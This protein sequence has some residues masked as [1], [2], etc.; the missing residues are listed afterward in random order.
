MAKTKT[1]PADLVDPMATVKNG[2]PRPDAG[3][4]ALRLAES[5]RDVPT[6]QELAKMAPLQR[7]QACLQGPSLILPGDLSFGQWA[8][9]GPVL[10]QL[11]T[12]LQFAIGDWLNYGENRYGEKYAQVADTLAYDRA[13]LMNVAWVSR[14]IE[15]SR[16]REIVPFAYHQEVAAAGLSV[17]DREELLDRAVQGTDGQGRPILVGRAAFRAFVRDYR[18]LRALPDPVKPGKV[19]ALGDKVAKD[20]AAA[21]EEVAEANAVAAESDAIF[22]DESPSLVTVRQSMVDPVFGG[23]RPPDDMRDA[24]TP[25]FFV[26]PSLAPSQW[27]VPEDTDLSDE[28]VAA[29]LEPDASRLNEEAFA[30]SLQDKLFDMEGQVASLTAQM[31][32]LSEIPYQEQPWGTWLRISEGHTKR[33]KALQGRLEERGQSYTLA[34]VLEISIDKACEALKVKVAE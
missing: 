13:Y 7:I 11:S 28:D 25:G 18:K 29:A 6:A 30:Q 23:E 34:G 16:R 5:E 26:G 20:I 19:G 17:D 3:E 4:T 21:T 12:R 14:A 15:I 24:E 1:R 31:A 22:E 33:L 32:G 10:R 2:T 9:L 27:T 8:E